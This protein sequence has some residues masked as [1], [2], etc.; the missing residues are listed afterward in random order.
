[1]LKIIVIFLYVP[2]CILCLTVRIYNYETPCTHEANDSFIKVELCKALLRML[3]P[4]IRSYLKSILK[5]KYI[6]S[7][8]YHPDA[9]YLREKGCE[10][11]WSFLEVKSGPREKVFG[12]HCS[13][14]WVSDL[15][16]KW[17]KRDCGQHSRNRNKWYT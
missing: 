3:L 10:D 5:F 15:F 14:P 11:P 7:D 16:R 13:R 8:T 17:S 2:V 1:L 12:K 6:F 4:C 9:I